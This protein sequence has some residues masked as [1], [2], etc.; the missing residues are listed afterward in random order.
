MINDIYGGDFGHCK[1]IDILPDGKFNA[2]FIVPID[3]DTNKN[4]D[5]TAKNIQDHWNA[6]CIVSDSGDNVVTISY[7]LHNENNAILTKSTDDNV[8]VISNMNRHNKV[9]MPWNASE[10]MDC[11]R[12]LIAATI[13]SD[14]K[15]YLDQSIE[16]SERIELND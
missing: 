10:Q 9:R 16:R 11:V 13:I 4:P 12:D 8:E 2:L 3:L 15:K 5:N 7:S 6:S 1:K 14:I